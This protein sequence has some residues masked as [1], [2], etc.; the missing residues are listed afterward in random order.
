MLD[1]TK[2]FTTYSSID[3]IRIVER[4][5]DYQPSAVEAA[6]AILATR[7]VTDQDFEV[8]KNELAALNRQKE[9]QAEKK[10]EFE[11]KIKNIGVSIVSFVNPLQAKSLSSDRTIKVL[12]IIFG[13]YS[14]FLLYNEIGMISF[15]FSNSQVKWELSTVLDFLT[16][17]LLP[18]GTILFLKR[19]KIGWILLSLFLTY[20]VIEVIT[21]FLLALNR[22]VSVPVLSSI[23][24]QDPPTSFIFPFLFFV[25]AL[26][27]IC[28]S[29]IR[30]IYT[31]DRK[32]MLR[33][34]G[35]A[36]IGS[37]LTIYVGLR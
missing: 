17:I 3:L 24:P 29:G 15:M 14:L 12:S 31:V 36:I 33:A 21:N 23:F 34:I 2:E 37:V 13:G 28:K 26:W 8:V 20:S 32:N 1:F 35:F 9:A 6:Q 25:G 11:I 30:N 5:T 16:S 27:V 18:T 10:E 22:K 7:Q 4:Q 19:I